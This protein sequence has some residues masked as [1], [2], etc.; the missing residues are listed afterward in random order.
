MKFPAGFDPL[1]IRDPP[2]ASVGAAADVADVD[3]QM[4]R[5]YSDYSDDGT[6]GA[7]GLIWR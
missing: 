5:D 2:A 6:T 7:A 4:D 3:R 1:K